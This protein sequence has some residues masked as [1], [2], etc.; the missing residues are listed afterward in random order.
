M[1]SNQT[2]ILLFVSSVFILRRNMWFQF[3]SRWWLRLLS[4]NFLFFLC[5][6]TSVRLCACVS[7]CVNV[8]VYMPANVHQKK[9]MMSLIW[10]VNYNC[11]CWCLT[12]TQLGWSYLNKKRKKIRNVDLY[13]FCCPKHLHLLLLAAGGI[14]QQKSEEVWDHSRELCQAIV[15]L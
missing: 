15:M 9:K 5:L 4:T 1:T 7:L 2:N 3:E 14:L 11:T 12:E 13:I 8:Y 6:F 10:S